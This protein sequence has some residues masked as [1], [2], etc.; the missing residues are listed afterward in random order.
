MIDDFKQYEGKVIIV[1]CV[2][3]T[4]E[5][6]LCVFAGLDYDIDDRPYYSVRIKR[7]WYLTEIPE[8]SVETIEIS[9]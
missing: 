6:G 1:H 5:T 3:G 7:D 2:D 8:Q 4:T 9:I